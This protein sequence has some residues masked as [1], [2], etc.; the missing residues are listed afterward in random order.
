MLDAPGVSAVKLDES[1]VN[2]PGQTNGKKGKSRPAPP[3]PT[4]RNQQNST[5]TGTDSDDHSQR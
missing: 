5:T 1:N 2:Y 4:P 3:I